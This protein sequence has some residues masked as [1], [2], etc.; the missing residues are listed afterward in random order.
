MALSTSKNLLIGYLYRT[1]ANSALQTRVYHLAEPETVLCKGW[2]NLIT[3]ARGND[4]GN[5]LEPASG[6]FGRGSIG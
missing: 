3:T 2:Y 6:C 4:K 5:D 1:I